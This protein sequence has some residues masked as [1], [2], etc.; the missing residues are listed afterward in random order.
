[1]EESTKIIKSICEDGNIDAV[2]DFINSNKL[3]RY[4]VNTLHYACKGGNV[5]IIERIAEMCIQTNNDSDIA[6]LWHN[7]LQ[8]AC[9]GGNL[10]IFKKYVNKIS[11]SCEYT[12]RGYM[13][14]FLKNAGMSGNLEL[15]D[16]IIS[17][18]GSGGTCGVGY[19]EILKGACKGGHTEII[20]L[21]AA[22]C[23][24]FRDSSELRKYLGL[25]CKQGQ[26]DM[27][28]YMIDN[29]WINDLDWDYALKMAC[30]GGHADIINIMMDYVDPKSGLII[31]CRSGNIKLVEYM[32]EKGS[33][34]WNTGL[35]AAC[36]GG[37][38]EIVELMISKGATDRDNKAFNEACQGSHVQIAKLMLK[39]GSNNVNLRLK[40]ACEFGLLEIAELIILQ[41]KVE[42][43]EINFNRALECV[44]EMRHLETRL[45]IVVLL[46][47]NGATFNE[48]NLKNACC[49][50]DLTLVQLMLK[51]EIN[52]WDVRTLTDVLKYTIKFNRERNRDQ[53][54]DRIMAKD[55]VKY[56][57]K[58]FDII[59]MLLINKGAKLVIVPPVANYHNFFRTT[60]NFR[61]YQFYCKHSGINP[62]T[63]EKY[64]ELL[65][66]YPPYVLLGASRLNKKICTSKL[67]TELYRLLF[68]YC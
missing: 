9:E 11:R 25:V 38:I 58:E 61:L 29:N 53:N 32:I 42:G 37:N 22:K 39:N 4:P 60:Y 50:S 65:C 55:I 5:E 40:S 67:P 2:K 16:Y 35:I 45:E 13:V 28:K 15:I 3:Y 21:M 27:V 63:D 66:L 52:N 7:G 31:T 48:Y 24:N 34:N 68:T 6:K 57:Y 41:C 12:W 17:Q 1:M 14:S 19:Y 46:V 47:E 8:G 56:R 36:K 62:F 10:D 26:I 18:G 59:V 43:K 64:Q 30:C 51:P 20:K 54:R 33:T 49:S 23:A 44:C